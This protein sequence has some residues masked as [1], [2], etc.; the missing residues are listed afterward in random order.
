[1]YYSAIQTTSEPKE[2]EAEPI[3]A[4]KFEEGDNTMIAEVEDLK[5]KLEDNALLGPRYVFD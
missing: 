2:K 1:M 4:V 5:V 3:D